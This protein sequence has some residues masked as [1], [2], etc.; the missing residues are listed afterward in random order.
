MSRAQLEAEV[1]R[2]RSH[3]TSLAQMFEQAPSFIAL[4]SGPE[5]RFTLTNA[6]YHRAVGG[7]DVIG[8]TVAEALPEAAAQ[9]YV[10]LLDEVF[11]SGKPHRATGARLDLQP[12]PDGPVH[13][14][15]LDFVYQPISGADGRV[16]GIFV[17]GHDVTERSLADAALRE[18][19]ARYR[20]LFESIEVGFCVIEMKFDGGRAVDYRIV[21]ANPAFVRQTGADVAGKWVSEFAPDLERHWFDTYG[22]VALTGQPAHLEHYADVFGRWFDVRAL[23]IGDPAAHRVA[24]FFSD[25]TERRNVERRAEAGERELRLIADALPVL[26]SFIGDDFVYRFA[27]KA[28]EDWFFLPPER[29]VGRDVRDLLTPDGFAAREPFM[30]RALA[31]ESVTFEMDWPHRDGRPRIAEIRYLPR[32]AVGG[33]VDGYH[34]FVQDVTVR[35]QTEADLA[36]QVAVRTAE[37]DQIWQASSDLLCVANFDGYFVSLNPAWIRTL[38]WT[39]AEMKAR[40]FLDFVHPDDVAATVGAAS[41]LSRGEVQLTFENRYLHKDGGHIWL[42]WNAVPRDGLIYASVRDVTEIKRQAEALA[43]TE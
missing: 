21:E 12:V 28:Y 22:D 34:V 40:P 35:A 7:R 13:E 39:E 14:R 10:G 36:H 26:I 20:T 8:Q 38:G 4:L 23:R 31:G 32:R 6:A 43:R 17:E 3:S 18:S 11:R 19:E 30:R 24:V 29:V 42:S 16:E 41:G 1:R 5:H 37:R 9:G 27:N 15:Y 33:R 25:I 2:L